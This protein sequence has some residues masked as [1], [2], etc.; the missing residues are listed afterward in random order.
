MTSKLCIALSA[1]TAWS[2]EIQVRPEVISTSYTYKKEIINGKKSCSEI[3]L[4]RMQGELWQ[5]PGDVAL[6]LDCVFLWENVYKIS[7]KQ[8]WVYSN[9]SSLFLSFPAPNSPHP[10]HD[11]FLFLWFY[12]L[13]ALVSW[14]LASAKCFGLKCL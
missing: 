14:G 12:W 11:H 13:Q 2:L 10:P 8:N 3:P 7:L 5:R 4:Y 9:L 6:I 1:T